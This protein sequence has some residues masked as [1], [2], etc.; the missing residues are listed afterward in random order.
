VELEGEGGSAPGEDDDGAVHGGAVEAGVRVPPQRALLLGEDDPVGEGG[1]G[2]DGALRDVLR[3][4]GPRV[5]RLIHAVPARAS[6]SA[7]ARTPTD[8]D[9]AM[10]DYR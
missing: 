2:L 7:L 9:A 1:A 10:E 5:P 6:S 3:P 4:V 8:D